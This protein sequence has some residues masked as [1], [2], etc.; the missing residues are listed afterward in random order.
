MRGPGRDRVD[1]RAEFR[2]ASHTRRIASLFIQVLPLAIVCAVSPWAIVAVILMLASAR[3]FNSVGWLAGWT[4]ST[5]AIGLLFIFFLGGYDFSK[6]STPTKAASTAQVVLGAFLLVVSLRFWAR[7]PARTGTLPAEPGW[8]KKI[9][10][11]RFIWAFLIGA[12]WINTTLVVAAG[13]D[14][15][16]ANLPNGEAIAVFALFTLVTLSVQGVLILY[17]Y[18]LPERAG[19]GLAHFRERIARNQDVGL[20]AIALLIGV[21]LA[22][23]G[24]HGLR[25]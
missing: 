10:S 23:K 1:A 13:I 16:R 2:A 25:A 6:A 19:V 4:T 24:I 22:V 5:F 3:P 21:W 7:R 8:M 11:M 15:V 9:G 20:A 14:T 12:F 17:A 18:L